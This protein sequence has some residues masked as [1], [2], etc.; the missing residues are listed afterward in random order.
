MLLWKE[1]FDRL[2]EAATVFRGDGRAVAVN[3]ACCALF[4]YSR[5]EFADPSFNWL[6]HFD[7]ADLPR[8][9]GEIGKL[10]KGSA[11]VVYYEAAMSTR[12]G[13]KLWIGNTDSCLGIWP[14][15]GPEP[16]YLCLM[17]NETQR[18]AELQQRLDDYRT[19]LLE[20][21]STWQVLLE[22]LPF[23]VAGMDDRGRQL[24]V[25]RRCQALIGGMRA[26]HVV[27]NQE[28]HARFLALLQQ[29]G[30][31]VPATG[32][33]HV[34]H[35]EQGTLPV[36][37]AVVS[38]PDNLRRNLGMA[39]LMTLTDISGLKERECAMERQRTYFREL[40]DSAPVAIVVG[41]PHGSVLDANKAH[42]RLLGVTMEELL[43]PGFN[44]F[45]F[46][47]PE[48]HDLDRQMISTFVTN[49]QPVTWEKE[50]Q[51]R[52]GSRIWVE[53]YMKAFDQ[54]LPGHEDRWIITI[55]DVTRRKQ[56]ALALERI[57]DTVRQGLT[58][59]RT[60]DFSARWHGWFEAEHAA[61]GEAMDSLAEVLQQ[62]VLHLQHSAAAVREASDAVEGGA[63]SL[64][65]RLQQ[66]ATSLE[67]SSNATEQ[68]N[69]SARD[70]AQRAANAAELAHHVATSALHATENA[71]EAMGTMS[72][73]ASSSQ[74]VGSFLEVI[75]SIAF[76]TNILALNAA[77]EA[78]HA[79]E[80][81]QGFAVVADEVR[82]LAQGSAQAAA[83]VVQV[84]ARNQQAIEAGQRSVNALHQALTGIRERNAELEQL[85][86][87]MAQASAEQ[88]GAMD[89][90]TGALRDITRLTQ[91]NAA[92]VDRLA[93]AAA[94]LSR[95]ATD[96]VQQ[97]SSM[98]RTS[99]P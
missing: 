98:G 70:N 45:A 93:E 90:I 89:Q 63:H 30:A 99:G 76:H 43:R 5:A 50:F 97:A 95:E 6:D 64:S 42:A 10:A 66:E 55:A 59:L 12:D 78:A 86:E 18:R 58:A 88:S 32:E 21:R 2:G 54:P 37:C 39:Y 24:Y 61:L 26:D 11:Q 46:T 65:Q 80:S 14:E 67:Q 25:N 82:R 53:V 38:L 87:A 44:Q 7:K 15:H 19:E 22:Q 16:L 83:D 73:I 35:A 40:F 23:P 17:T 81:G 77:I 79:G 72:A 84:M 3:T 62:A 49:R 27:L 41:D 4:G 57:I 51:R 8:I 31:D 60:G 94:A 68:T 34:S 1:A 52:D 13:R 33:F 85:L 47:P 48:Y 29:A 28:E 92:L 91:E 71:H 75:R 56:L 69:T 96:L 74:E 20:A 9:G 36:M